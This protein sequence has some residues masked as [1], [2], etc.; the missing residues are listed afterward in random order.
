MEIKL[1]LVQQLLKEIAL[2]K[3]VCPT[4]IYALVHSNLKSEVTIWVLKI[5]MLQIYR[6]KEHSCFSACCDN[7]GEVGHFS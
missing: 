3:F 6:L 5:N 4:E 2:T 7:F 1:M